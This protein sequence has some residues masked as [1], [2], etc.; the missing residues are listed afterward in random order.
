MLQR[1]RDRQRGGA[2][3]FWL[4]YVTW[5]HVTKYVIRYVTKYVIRYV[6]RHRGYV[7]AIVCMEVCKNCMYGDLLRF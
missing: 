3:H 2:G 5:Y 6:I 1:D 4:K 7:M